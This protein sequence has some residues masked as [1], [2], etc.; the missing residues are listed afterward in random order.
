VRVCVND[1]IY[2]HP[3]VQLDEP[4][5]VFTGIEMAGGMDYK[6]RVRVIVHAGDAPQHGQEFHDFGRNR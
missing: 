6:S 2:N 3:A 1:E 5:D 4:E